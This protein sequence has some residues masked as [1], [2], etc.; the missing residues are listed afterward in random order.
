MN[1][2]KLF[3]NKSKNL[4]E[5]KIPTIVFFGDSV[6]QGCF[7]L[8]KKS[9]TEYETEFRSHYAY[10]TYLKQLLATL[11][12]NV[13]VNMINAG[14]S[15]DNTIGAVKRLE[16]DVLSYNPDL[17]V[18]CFGL[19]DVWGGA[20]GLE[21]YADNLRTIFKRLKENGSEVIFM[22][23]NMMNTYV[24]YRLEEKEFIDTAYN[25]MKEQ[26]NG[27]LDMYFNKAKEIASEQDVVVC[28]VY[29]K[30]KR[31]N[32]LGVDTTE[33]LANHINHPT[34]E[35]NWLFANS[36]LETMMS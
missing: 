20:N 12:P 34:K 32:E 14:I 15:G 24:S 31:M 8:Y 33:L 10:H 13:P 2:I 19:N 29:A 16:R 27:T 4:R 11:F 35:M 21:L 3:A 26:N 36:L 1:I 28:D 7:E 30:W 22:T 6:T 23:A 17:T 25:T 18:V 9:D 5:N